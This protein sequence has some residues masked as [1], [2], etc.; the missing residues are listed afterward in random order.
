MLLQ[1][2]GTLLQ[3][4]G[5]EQLA[6]LPV[7]RDQSAGIVMTA[8]HQHHADAQ[9]AEHVFIKRFQPLVAVEADQQA[10]KMK[11]V[12][13]GVRPVPVVDR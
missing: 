4:S 9:F 3:F 8:V 7:D 12:T 13:D 10:V 11:V 1:Y 6:H 2:I 5:S